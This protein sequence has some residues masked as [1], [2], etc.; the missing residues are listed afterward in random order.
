[1]E[2]KEYLKDLLNNPTCRVGKPQNFTPFTEDVID[3]IIKDLKGSVQLR[4][5]NEVFSSILE[6]AMSD[7]INVIDS[8]YYQSVKSE[9]IG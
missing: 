5:Y 1:M 4:K 7:K 6:H 3:C 2:V 8:G 9:V